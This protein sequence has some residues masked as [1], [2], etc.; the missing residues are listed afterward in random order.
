MSETAGGIALVRV[1]VAPVQ[2]EPRVSGE[3]V[4]QALFGRVVW[5]T[6]RAGD[7]YHVRTT[8]DGYAGWA[9]AG[10]LA[11]V[12]GAVVDG[13]EVA[14]ALAA[15]ES[16]GAGPAVPGVPTDGQRTSLGCVVRV[17][18]RTLHL[19]LGAWLGPDAQVLD[20]EAVP[21]GE[22]PV[23][24]PRGGEAVAR[25]AARYFTS[26]S[27]QW[28]GVT[29]WGA[30]CSGFVQ[31]VFALHGVDLPRDASPQARVGADVGADLLAHAPGDLLFFSEREDGRVTH[32]GLA[33]GGGR[34][35]HVALGRGGFAGEDL[36][37]S[38]D[39][40]VAALRGRFVGARRVLG[41]G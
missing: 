32:V 36:A 26:T 41:P 19:P 18:G 4:T 23:R 39:P 15:V 20:G 24:F 14:E 37:A 16:D 8:P 25:T 1:P 40:Y 35:L 34:M 9:H 13:A 10:Y 38:D 33:A 22:L 17:G 31:T 27:Y 6:E 29:P 3:Q 28:G 7:W 11:V 21:M 30:D 12:D 5:W 2:R